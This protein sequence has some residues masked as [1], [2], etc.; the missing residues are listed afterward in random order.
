M[1]NI[2][3]IS[4]LKKEKCCGC[5]SCYNICPKKA[6]SMVKDSEG[7]FY[8]NVSE[9]MCINCGKCIQ[10]CPDI[11]TPDMNPFDKAY[12]CYA[13]REEE[14]LSSSSGG[15]FAVLAREILEE[16]GIVCGAAF[17][18]SV[19]VKHII[20]DN[21][22]GLEKIKKTKYV[23]STIGQAYSQIKGVLKTG[24]KVL[25]SGTPCQVAGL[26][27]Y[28]GQDYDNLICIDLICHGVPSPEVFSRY[29]SE[30]S[31]NNKIVAMTFRNKENGVYNS[32]LEYLLDNGEKISETYEESPYIKGFNQNLFIRPSCFNCKYKG[33]KRCSDITIGD[34]WGIDEF[35]PNFS[36]SY[37]TSAVIIHSEKGI[38]MFERIKEKLQFIEVTS[39][40]IGAWNPCLYKP[41]ENNLNR[42]VFFEEIKCKTIAEAVI[43]L[44]DHD[45]KKGQL[46]IVYSIFKKTK[47]ILLKRIIKKYQ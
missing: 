47:R 37:G 9:D 27:L 15:F 34:F 19:K 28:L 18:D 8:P 25:F 46:K 16:N 2:G 23:Q 11:K 5:H 30:K 31:R 7:F 20:T 6:I 12:A 24:K 1:N 4:I 40:E 32:I 21:I 13:K 39:Q 22:S 35:H 3:N 41:V 14:H 43:E 42:D 36:D 33:I 45:C 29:L 17:D 10:S 44:Q 26:K 38:R